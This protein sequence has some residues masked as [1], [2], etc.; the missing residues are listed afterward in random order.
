MISSQDPISPIH[1]DDVVVGLLDERVENLILAHG[2]DFFRIK[3]LRIEAAA[4]DDRH[5]G[6]HRHLAQE[7]DVPA[8][9]LVS[10]IDDAGKVAFAR[11]L[12]NFSGHQV[13]AVHDVRA[14][15][16]STTAAGS[17]RNGRQSI[18]GARGC[19]GCGEPDVKVRRELEVFVKQRGSAGQ[20]FRCVVFEDGPND[21]ALRKY[22]LLRE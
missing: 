16:R 14:G 15:R 13:H 2:C 10:S 9:L 7:V 6:L 5:A 18:R 21:G 11:S 19:G 1:A 17:R 4:R 8:H 20:L 12:H 3:R 22:R